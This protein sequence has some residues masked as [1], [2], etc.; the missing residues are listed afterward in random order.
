M[1]SPDALELWG[2]CPRCASWF[3][4]HVDVAG[5]VAWEC[6]ACGDL[7][8]RVE[9]RVLAVHGGVAPRPTTPSEYWHG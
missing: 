7:P 2:R 3:H 6:P 5:N 9:S 1:Q 8:D 4:I